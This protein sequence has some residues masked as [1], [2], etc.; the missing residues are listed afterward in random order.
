MRKAINKKKMNKRR[1]IIGILIVIG[2]LAIEFPGIL[3]VRNRI[4]PFIL[5]IPVVGRICVLYFFMLTEHLG[6]NSRFLKNL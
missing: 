2:F 6:E 5:G 1:L 3:L 4:Y